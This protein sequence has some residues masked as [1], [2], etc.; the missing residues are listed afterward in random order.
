MNKPTIDLC[1][2]AQIEAWKKEHGSVFKFVAEDGKIGF[3]KKPDLKT[4]EASLTIASTNPIQ[5]NRILAKNTFIGGDVEV[6]E[7]DAHLLGLGK[8]LRGIIKSVEGEL[9]EL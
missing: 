4:M 3:F 7:D 6:Y 2:P 9:T 8:T 1:T 5:S